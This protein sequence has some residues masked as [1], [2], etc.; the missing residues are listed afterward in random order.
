[1]SNRGEVTLPNHNDPDLN[2]EVRK[3]R[4]RQANALARSGQE[5]DL[6][7]KR[8]L[9][10]AM[11]RIRS[12]DKELFTHKI[13]MSE[14]ATHLGSNPYAR[15]ERAARGLLRRLVYVPTE[16]GGFKEFQW[17][18]VAEYVPS[19]SSE[20]GESYVKIRLNE[21][22]AP[23]LLELRERYNTIPLLD[24]L[25]ME[26]FN[27]QRLYEILWH[28]S[29]GG[30]KKV[31]TY[32]ITDLKF[33]LGMRTLE[34]RGS[35]K[36][37]VEKYKAWRDF[38]KM[39]ERA[40]EEF[41]THGRLRFTF[42]ALRQG[43]AIQQVRFHL[44][45][46]NNKSPLTTSTEQFVTE[47]RSQEAILLEGE[48]RD[49][50]YVQDPAAIIQNHGLEVV[51]QAIT[52]GRAA[53]TRSRNTSRPINNLPGFIQHLLTSGAAARS[54]ASAREKKD[55]RRDEAE[56]TRA[57]KTAFEVFQN[58]VAEGVFVSLAKD[59]REAL[60]EMLRVELEAQRRSYLIDV[61]DKGGW[62]G[63]QYQL[64]RN[65]YLLD[66]YRDELPD[67]AREVRR[68]VRGHALVSG[69][70]GETVERICTTLEAEFGSPT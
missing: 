36:V 10:L 27:G 42:D 1:M 68:F 20:L 29:H 41:L 8:L 22:L 25:P 31:L 9:L 70:P 17:T 32:A 35:K 66:L 39:L 24:L 38:R 50:G 4:I 55:P 30:E 45:F 67:D 56:L 23:L 13:G 53:E 44:A 28:D 43:R 34:Q 7:E 11:S 61:L 16:N 37:W 2:L 57:L 54:L 18:T 52:L 51:R 3:A 60:P 33:S 19:E 64:A 69:L 48:L 65:T 46:M 59:T 14:L 40:Q 12:S 62:E 63:P 6:N 26:S 49:L 21:E 15:A 5:L 47:P 58:E